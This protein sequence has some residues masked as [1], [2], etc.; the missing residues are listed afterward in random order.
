MDGRTKSGHD[1]VGIAVFALQLSRYGFNDNAVCLGPQVASVLDL[2]IV[3]PE[4]SQCD[5]YAARVEVRAHDTTVIEIATESRK[6]YDGAL[7]GL[8]GLRTSS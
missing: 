1:G 8:G 6:V 2:L 4:L 3:L 5:W 7:R